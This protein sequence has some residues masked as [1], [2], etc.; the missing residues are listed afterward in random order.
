MS[1]DFA[2][3]TFAWTS[4]APGAAV[5][6]VVFVGF[7]EKGVGGAKQLFDYPELKGQP[8]AISA[9][10][11]NI[12]L[13]DSAVTAIGKHASPLV[14]VPRL[15]EGNRPQDG[16]GLLVSPW[17]R[18]E[19]MRE[20]P[21][22]AGYLRRLVGAH[23]MIHDE[24]RWCLW[25]VDADPRDV[26]R[27]P[28]LREHMAV[29]KAA[30]LRSPTPSARDKAVTPGL[31]LAMRQPTQ[32]WL[33][34]PRHSSEHRP[35]I[36][37]EFFTSQDIAHDSTLTLA[38]ADEY[39]LGVLQSTMFTVWAKT[40]SGRIKSDIRVSPDLSYNSFP[41][42][43]PT[44]TQRT[45]VDAAAQQVLGAREA[46]PQS[47]LADLYGPGMPTDVRAAHKTLDTGVDAM[48][49]RRAYKTEAAR[50]ALLFDLYGGLTGATLI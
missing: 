25:L 1:I 41:F 6:H 49:G 44:P 43:S 37:M 42:P 48:F 31:F 26:R 9:K 23:D 20:D 33:C 50:Q 8:I 28:V 36:P 19:I 45:R 30:R 5:V 39:L 24:R 7:S 16:G 40:V 4:E 35:V 12:Y 17:E 18:E 29:V 34:V 13:A 10:A 3:R 38:G 2:H 32:R 22:A 47:S 15:T 27:S 21:L 46:H 11:V 14:P